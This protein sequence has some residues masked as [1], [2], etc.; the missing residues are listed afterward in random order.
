[1]PLQI[2]KSKTNLTVDVIE[3]YFSAA[4]KMDYK[5]KLFLLILS[6]TLLRI[7]A[8]S[9]TELGNDEAYY[10]TYAQHLQWSYFDHPPLVGIWIRF[11]TAN[12]VLENFEL[13]IR[14]GSIISCAISTVIIFKL[15]KELT[16][17]RAGFIAACLYTTSLYASISAGTFI[18]P[19]SP[20]L[21]FWSSSL[22]FIMKILKAPSAF[23]YWVL[24]AVTA[25]LAIM[26]KVHGAFIWV[27][28]LLF[29]IIRQQKLLRSIHLY[30]AFVISF[31]IT[32]PILFWNISNDFASFNFQ[33]SRLSSSSSL[34]NWSGLLQEIYG[35]ILFTNPINFLVIITALLAT[36]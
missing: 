22:Y 28:F 6:A 3:S 23:K 30:T 11:F 8:A 19:D 16:S 36:M 1:M 32:S 15:L 20:Q 35:Q 17:E 33:T 26:S 18:L 31:I 34:I 7:V 29:I 14:L 5:R 21:L 4:K 27:G 2:Y 9:F 24:F 25:G 13:L 12:L 10:W